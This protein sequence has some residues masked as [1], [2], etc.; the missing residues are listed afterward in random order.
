VFVKQKNYKYRDVVFMEVCTSIRNNL[1]MHPNER[2]E[3]PTMV[4]VDES[5]KSSL[6]DDDEERDE[7]VKYPLVANEEA[8]EI[9]VEKIR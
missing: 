5:F 1:E 3:R 7:Q 6:C 2:N 9:H 8:I 4:V